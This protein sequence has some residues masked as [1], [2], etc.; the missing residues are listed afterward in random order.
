MT[1]KQQ[2]QVELWDIEDIKPHPKNAKIHDDVQV[3]KLARSIQKFGWAAPIVVWKDGVI[4]AGHGRRLA[5]LKLGL[6]KVPVIVRRDLTEAE[7]DALRLADNRITSTD[8]DQSLLQE[9]LRELSGEIDMT[10][11]GFDPKELEFVTAD[12]G[13][14]DTSTFIDDISGA[15]EQQRSQ[16]ETKVQE[17]DD[18]AAPLAD[19]FGFKRVTI[20][21][22]RAIRDV[23]TK[24]EAKSG[25][26]GV[27]ALLA[28]LDDAREALKL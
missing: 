5:A 15:V 24:Y 7:A 17:V 13:E 14:I 6:Q 1:N 23:M 21:Q 4:I 8:Y 3:E 11:A 16:N 27:D 12:L 25:L 2:H 18:V 26:K 10:F 20:A 19:A 28:F 9:V 22:S